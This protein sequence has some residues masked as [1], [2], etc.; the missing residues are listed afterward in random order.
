MTDYTSI[1]R[2][3]YSSFISEHKKEMDKSFLSVY[4]DAIEMY[5]DI[6][7]ST[8]I[9]LPGIAGEV[10]TVLERTKATKNIPPFLLSEE[11]YIIKEGM[12]SWYLNLLYNKI[13]V[14]YKRRLEDDFQMFD[15]TTVELFARTSII[16]ISDN[17]W[18]DAYPSTA[19]LNLRRN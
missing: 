7:L 5:S 13:S 14:Y 8:L 10:I 1:Y 12:K 3:V 18:T 11:F 17:I 16:H 15:K 19:E 4:E 9:L 2:D 6:L